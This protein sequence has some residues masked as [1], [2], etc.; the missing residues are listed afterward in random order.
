MKP[1]DKVWMPACDLSHS[2]SNWNLS[3]LPYPR[4]IWWS[5]LGWDDYSQPRV[6]GTFDDRTANFTFEGK[7]RAHSFSLSNSSVPTDTGYYDEVPS[8]ISVQ[9]TIRFTI[10][11]LLDTYHSDVLSMNDTKPTWLR[12]VGFSNNSLNIGYSSDSS[13][14]PPRPGFGIKGFAVLFT[15]L[16]MLF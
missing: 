2:Y 14:V 8:T 6:N 15:M 16:S 11:G 7:F 13:D 10:E 4:D 12:T 1:I 3:I 9:G 5:T